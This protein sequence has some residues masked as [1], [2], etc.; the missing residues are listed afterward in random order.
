MQSALFI[1]RNI[2]ASLSFLAMAFWRAQASCFSQCSSWFNSSYVVIGFGL[3]GPIIISFLV[4]HIKKLMMSLCLICKL[5]HW[6]MIDKKPQIFQ[7]EFRD[8]YT[9]TKPPLKSMPINIY[10]SPSKIS[11]CSIYLLSIYQSICFV[12][13]HLT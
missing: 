11:S 6:G 13:G 7:L 3:V 8:K 5:F 9:P 4:H 12:I 1:C 2:S 10:P